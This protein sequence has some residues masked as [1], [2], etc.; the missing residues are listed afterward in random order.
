[1]KSAHNQHCPGSRKGIELNE[2]CSL[3]GGVECEGSNSRLLS[4]G[5]CL[6]MLTLLLSVTS[7]ALGQESRDRDQPSNAAGAATAG[8]PGAERSVGDARFLPPGTPSL[9]PGQAPIYRLG[10]MSRNT[11]TGVEIAQV[12]PNSVAQRAGLEAGDLIV[13]VAGYQV[14]LIGDR[15]FDI[16]DEL[17]RRVD[18]R[19]RVLLLVRNRRNGQLINVPC[20]FPIAM[21][22]VTGRILSSDNRPLLANQTLVVRVVD[23]TR[24]NW[25]DSVIAETSLGSPRLWPL[26][27]RLEID[28]DLI[29]AG[30]RYAVVARVLQQGVVFQ[31][32]GSPM[33]LSFADAG[34]R[35]N[36][37]LRRLQTPVAPLAPMDQIQIWYQQLLG[38]QPTPRELNAW[39]SD[40]SRG[41]SLQDVQAT[42]MSGSEYYERNQSSND[43]FVTESYQQLNKV[44]PTTAQQEELKRQLE[45]QNG[46]RLKFLQDLQRQLQGK[47]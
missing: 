15:L 47:Q 16:G 40:L 42:I 35:I 41:R 27:Y 46:I 1:M 18:R 45:Q 21:K 36:L 10:I 43:R 38:R 19:G 13:A 9:G 14:G 25:N 23:V 31:D 7:L 20:E 30:R 33:E 37:T 22:V 12:M 11:N 44:A 8:G 24:P 5:S 32:T 2:T 29:Q 4:R 3:R 26:D 34:D 17:S 6:A 39:Q 28:P